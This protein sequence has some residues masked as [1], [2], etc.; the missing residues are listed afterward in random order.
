M[1]WDAL[2]WLVLA[3]SGA[4]PPQRVQAYDTL[5]SVPITISVMEDR[6]G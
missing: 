3:V 5:C 4:N 1:R 6:S 2:A